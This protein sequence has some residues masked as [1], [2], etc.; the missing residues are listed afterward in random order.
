[1]E[2]TTYS[3]FRQHLKSYLDSVFASRAPLF[4][5]RSKGDDVVVLAKADYEGMQETIHL[6][7]NPKNAQRID[8]AL[9][10]YNQGKGEP[11]ELID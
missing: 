7:S 5:T 3:N 6:L 4:I 11:K 1:M 9:Q 2:I 8:E 10:E